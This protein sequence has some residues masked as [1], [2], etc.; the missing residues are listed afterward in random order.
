MILD[1]IS[2]AMRLSKIVFIL[3]L[4]KTTLIFSIYKNKKIYILMNLKE[5]KHPLFFK[6]LG[7]GFEPLNFATIHKIP[8]SSSFCGPQYPALKNTL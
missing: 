5:Q 1:F 7:F 4:L 2:K 8:M 3:V 6:A